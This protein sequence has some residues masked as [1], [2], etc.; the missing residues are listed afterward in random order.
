MQ[1]EPLIDSSRL[2]IPSLR[3]NLGAGL[4]GLP[5]GAGSGLEAIG[6]GAGSSIIPLAGIAAAA[7]LLYKHDKKGRKRAGK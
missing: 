6:Q 1:A 7:I 5:G 4:G 3:G 2:A